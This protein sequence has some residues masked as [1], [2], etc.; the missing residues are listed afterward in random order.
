M[1]IKNKFAT[2]VATASLLAGLFGSAFV[3][4]ALAA[5]EVPLDTPSVAKTET[6][7]GDDDYIMPV[8]GSNGVVT[9]ADRA[10]WASTVELDFDNNYQSDYVYVLDDQALDE[11]T[12]EY[13]LL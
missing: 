10:F 1:S 5:R 2:A 12:I 8:L 4:S 13:Y 3:P 6:W 11:Q 7:T 9:G